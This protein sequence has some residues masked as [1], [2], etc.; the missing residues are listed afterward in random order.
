MKSKGE[1]R[2][3]ALV[4]SKIASRGVV[5]GPDE[6]EHAENGPLLPTADAQDLASPLAAEAIIH[7]RTAVP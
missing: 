7:L 4:A 3:I 6:R 1:A 2:V 5:K